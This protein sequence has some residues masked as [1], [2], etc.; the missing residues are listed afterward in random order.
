MLKNMFWIPVPCVRD[1]GSGV[2]KSLRIAFPG[3]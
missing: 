3:T 1:M 2:T